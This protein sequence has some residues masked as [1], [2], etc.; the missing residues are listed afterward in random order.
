MSHR[1]D[2]EALSPPQ[3][4]KLLSSTVVPRPIALV[5]TLSR[6]G[7]PNAAPFS[8]FNAL[9]EDPP[10]L[11]LGLQENDDRS[12]KDTTANIRDTGE[13]VV[14][15]VDEAIAEAM[16][17]CAVNFPAGVNECE[18]AGLT[19]TASERVRPPRIAEAPV[20]FECERIALI[21]VSPGRH[22]ALGK[23]IL[24]HARE[25][26][27]DP[28]TLR[29]DTAAYRPVGRL[30]GSLYARTHDQFEMR[31]QTYEEWLAT[32]AASAKPAS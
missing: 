2:L 7:R 14:N 9:G 6:G 1:F 13:F 15:L 31:R 4:Y 8:F 10:V 28:A 19:L 3:Q 22:I 30:F 25:G 32:K 27:I 12:L 21:Q 20:A 16:N 24:M 17:V 11:V 26:I 23:A 5:T 18:A 29:V